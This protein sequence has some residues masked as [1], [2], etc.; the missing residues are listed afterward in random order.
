MPKEWFLL[1]FGFAILALMFLPAVGSDNVSA[2]P[3]PFS[4]LVPLDATFTPP[5]AEGLAAGPEFSTVDNGSGFLTD[6]VRITAEVIA[7]AAAGA[8]ALIGSAAAYLLTR[9]PT[10]GASMAS[11][12]GPASGPRFFNFRGRFRPVTWLAPLGGGLVFFGLAFAG[13]V[14][15][16][17]HPCF[18]PIGEEVVI[19]T[20][21]VRG[22][23]VPRW[24]NDLDKL[25]LDCYDLGRG[26][27]NA[28]DLARDEFDVDPFGLVP[29]EPSGYFAEYLTEVVEFDD[30]RLSSEITRLENQIAFHEGVRDSLDDVYG[31][32]GNRV[33]PEE[34]LETARSVCQD[35]TQARKQADI[36]WGVMQGRGISPVSP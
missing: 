28:F 5:V 24:A 16:R 9:R 29:T 30:S 23:E 8:V 26:G 7:Y 22:G 34:Q 35:L 4:T 13:C 31:A 33:S 19:V 25:K 18:Q 27:T 2:Q 10:G 36:I 21:D 14:D 3:G 32:L 11:V 20:C 17:S 1:S 6:A 12:G 15:L